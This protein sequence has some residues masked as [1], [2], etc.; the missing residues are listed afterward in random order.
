VYVCKAINEIGEAECS[1]QLVIE[2]APQFLKKLEKL[3][4]VE[5]CEAEWTFQL[6][7]I[8]KP[9]IEFSRN[10]E[11]FD[12]NNELYSLV[13]QEDYF[14]TLKFKN[15]SKKDVGNW[16]CTASNS[17]GKV[18]CVSKLETMPLSPPKF[19]KELSDCRLPQDCDNTLEVKVTGIP[20][21]QIEWSKDDQILDTKSDKYT[22]ERDMNNGNLKLIIKGCKIDVDSGLYKARIYNP[23]GECSSQGNVVVK[24]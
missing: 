6:I 2:M 24:G 13:E 20:F 4:A 17:A 22:S 5:S 21:P 12:L 3:D 8:P 18:S 14:Y 10:N 9:T 16:T 7:G 11:T 1:A 15:V 19:V 23:G